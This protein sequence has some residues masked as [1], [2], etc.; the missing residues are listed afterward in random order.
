MD[1]GPAQK[2][3][4][5]TMR[6]PRNGS[7]RDW[8]GALAARGPR[9]ASATTSAVCSPTAGAGRIAAGA[10]DDISHGGR[11][12]R[13]PRGLGTNTPRSTK[14]SIEGIVAPLPMWAIGTRKRLASTTI[15]S[16]VRAP[17]HGWIRA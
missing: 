12:C 7:P 5:S 3:V 16:T 11:G 4:K 15:S 2:A 14:W 9:R 1:D 10:H 17:S 13:N 6:T 8:D